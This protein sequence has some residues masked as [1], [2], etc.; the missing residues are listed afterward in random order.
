[1]RSAFLIVLLAGVLPLAAQDINGSI[2]G[3]VTDPSGATVPNA[4][5]TI[6]NTERNQVLRNLIT[7]DSGNF[8]APLLIIGKY[9]VTVEAVA[10]KKA[11]RTDIQL[12]VN[13]KLT[14]NLTLEVGSPTE[15]VTV[16][17]SALSVELQ[18][19]AGSTL[20]SGTQVRELSLN[21]RN[22]EQLVSLM[23]GVSSGASDQIYLGTTNPTGG[24]NTVSFSIN[25]QRASSNNW[26]VDG[27]D[28]V[29]RGSNQ[30]LL[31]YPSIDALAEFKVLR[32]SYSAELGRA[33][34]GQINVVTKS[35]T[36]EF[37]GVAYEF[38]RNNA[39]AANNWINNANSV[40]LG[41][42]GKARVP[43][44]RYNDFGYTIGGPVYIPGVYNKDKNKT[45]FFFSQ[46][47]RR[48]ITYGASQAIVPTANEK[49]GIF[50]VPVCVASSA[51]VCTQTATTIPNINPVA[52]AY[53]KDIFNQVPAGSALN[54]S[55]FVPLRS[56]YNA[57]QE[58]YKIDHNFGTKL[59]VFGRYLSDTIPTIEP[60]G[61]FTGSPLPGVA[62]TKTDSPGH[63]WVFRAQA[64]ITPTLLNEAGY[65]FSYGAITSDPT[66]LIGSQQSPDVKVPL[67]FAVSLQRLPSLTI[68]GGTGVAG[69]G[70]YRDFN[71]DHNA[72]DNLTKILG[73]H[74]IKAGASVH[75]YQKTENAS[76]NNVGSFSFS[77]TPAPAGTPT[78]QQAWANFLLGNVSQFTQ[79]SLDLT[80][81]IRL[82]QTEVYVQ[83]DFRLRPNLT[84]SYGIRYSNFRQPYDKNSFLTSFDP[85]K[86]DRSK[87]PQISTTNGNIISPVGTYD[88]LNG[89]IVNGLSSP[90]GKKVADESNY[91]FAP[92][93]GF[94]WD[95]TGGG[96]TA[97]RGGYGVYYD[98][99]LVGSFEQNIFQNPPYVQSATISNTRLE[100]PTAGTPI[101]SAGPGV[102]RATPVPF[103]IPYTQQW[104][105]DIQREIRKDLILDAGFVGT[106]GTHLLGIVDINQVQP[107]AGLAAGLHTGAGTA[108]TTADTPKLNAL[109]PYP[110]Y[111][112]I[113]Q[114]Q[115]AFDS[116]Y[117]GLQV[118]L[119]KRFGTN[120]SFNLSY[121]F[122]KNLTDNPSDRSN[123]PQNSYNWHEGEYGR[124]TFD[125]RHVLTFNYVYE[126]PFLKD[127]K[128][129]TGHV[130]GGWQISGI[131]QVGSGLPF[132]PT[133]SSVDPAGLGFLGASAAGP[134][135]DW[136][137][138]PNSNA[139]H[140][141]TQWFNTSCF[142]N[143]PAG[144]VRPG[145]AGRGVINGPG[146]QRWDTSLFKNI[147][148]GERLRLQI[149]G[150]AFN[151]FNHGN[152]LT[153]VTNI[154][155]STYGRV[156]AFR[157]PRI[158]QLGAKFY[159]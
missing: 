3:T 42:D 106:K 34:G 87:A 68:T 26:T 9:S 25:G 139:P 155:S 81:D 122:S 115:N 58:L 149:R 108:F 141:P 2:A 132:S 18:S 90:Y 67:P 136:I 20:I 83:D 70:P 126:L 24:T 133:T 8:S 98:A 15:Q 36:S 75:R 43:P 38:V 32:G 21:N 45:F 130:L 94:S 50:A 89:I 110:G 144:T 114:L 14:V 64:T 95:P 140:L 99:T 100:N 137:C 66:G 62:N 44:L 92:R 109:R 150:E 19:S 4:K 77:A 151:V 65:S 16:Q 91:N 131:T 157:D 120:G 158:I 102:L 103:H 119:E 5:V 93:F 153:I 29:D 101:V 76:G 63:S 72:Y 78:F 47:F 97:I 104:S 116:N 61:L 96:K 124:A 147:R 12:N 148:F 134:R 59:Q 80:P 85:E 53:I 41:S 1:M 10:F 159:F 54:N 7:D 156:T 125:R 73:R 49:Q 117:N 48:V 11:S 127:Q 28:N 37:H 60:G 105:F 74:S 46:E 23:P 111:N 79:A 55:L 123:A 135:P 113:N 57:R 112:A 128:S 52:A 13:D 86:F 33:A 71:R 39:F 152:P 17:E 154:T 121:T 6:V 40:N 107:G 31:N 143:V 138:D 27:A 146:Y 56:V 118:S 35:G 69:F 88:P 30:T 145:N 84:I 129:L 142:A 51:G 82:W 22:Y